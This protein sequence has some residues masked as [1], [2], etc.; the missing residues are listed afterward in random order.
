MKGRVQTGL[1]VFMVSVWWLPVAYLALLSVA[2]P[3][4]SD[5]VFPDSMSWTRWVRILSGGNGDLI[6]TTMA[7]LVLATVVSVVST[8]CG[9]I[10]SKAVA[11]SRWRGEWLALSH[12]AFGF[13]PVIL[14]SCLSFIAIRMGLSG[15]FLGV[16]MVQIAVTSAFATVLLVPVWTSER[17]AL[18]S[19]ART[20]GARPVQIWR[21]ILWPSCRP[22]VMVCWAQTFFFSWMQYGLTLTIGAGKVHT[23]PLEVYD[24]V[25][26]ADLGYAAV[27]SLILI[28]PPM[29]LLMMSPSAR[30]AWQNQGRA[31]EAATN[32]ER[33]V[34]AR[35]EEGNLPDA[36]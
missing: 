4:K 25:F 33:H 24:F 16:A 14:G 22:L 10:T 35:R 31:S 21:L 29:L 9:F 32:A 20:L 2:G 15:T 36:P 18:Q 3:W 27:A 26:E 30:P 13:S 34:K 23:L 17:R 7:S 8:T 12:L 19:V 6:K 11:E 5:H 1:T 28:I